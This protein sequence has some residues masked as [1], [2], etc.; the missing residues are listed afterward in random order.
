[1]SVSFPRSKISII[2]EKGSGPVPITVFGKIA[3]ILIDIAEDNPD[4]ILFYFCDIV[5]G[6]PNA[7]QGRSLLSH[8]YRNS[9]FKLLFQRYQSKAREHWSDIEIVL[10]SNDPPVEL[11]AHFLLRDKHMPLVNILKSEVSNNFAAISEEK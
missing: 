10:L 1:M 8:E 7:L 6:I 11:Y 4:T 9:L 5:E 3:D 2:R